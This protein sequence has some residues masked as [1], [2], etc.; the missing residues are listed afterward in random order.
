MADLRKADLEGAV[1][2]G[3]HLEGA[4]LEEAN[5]QGAD[6]QGACLQL[7]NL[8]GVRGLT[9]EQIESANTDENTRFPADS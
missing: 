4:N 9:R 7:T 5:L 8:T 2:A 1:L 3:A 6:L